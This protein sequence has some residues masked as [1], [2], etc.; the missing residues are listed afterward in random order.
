M[1]EKF[2]ETEK[3]SGIIIF[4]TDNPEEK[5][6]YL[7]SKN[8]TVSVRGGGIRV[9]PH[10]YNTKEDIDRIAAIEGIE[11]AYYA[12]P[13]IVDGQVKLTYVVVEKNLVRSITFKGNKKFK[14]GKLTKELSYRLGDYLDIFQ[15]RGGV[16]AIIELYRKKGYSFVEVASDE[17]GLSEGNVIYIINEGP[18]VKVKRVKFIGGK[19]IPPKELQKAIKTNTKKYLI[20]T[21]YFNEETL[22]KDIIKLQEA[23]QDRGFMNATVTESKEYSNNKKSVVVTFRI[24][25]GIVYTVQRISITGNEFIDDEALQVDTKLH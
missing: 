5:V 21:N 14:E 22:T 6:K 9:S 25:E 3:R 15:V 16:E 7:S 4:K 23:Y 8:I 17:S 18:R 13:E 1:S 12:E 11:Y 24:I 19:S 20:L 10:R 2:S